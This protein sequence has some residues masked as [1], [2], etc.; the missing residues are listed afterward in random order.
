MVRHVL[1]FEVAAQED[2]IPDTAFGKL[3]KMVQDISETVEGLNSNLIRHG[4]E[5][6]VHAFHLELEAINYQPIN[7]AKAAITEYLKEKGQETGISQVEIEQGQL[8]M[9]TTFGK[10]SS[11]GD[12]FREVGDRLDEWATELQVQLDGFRNNLGA[13]ANSMDDWK[14]GLTASGP[15]VGIRELEVQL[16][17]ML[18]E[19][20]GEVV[21]PTPEPAPA[22]EPTPE[23]EQGFA[24]RVK[25]DSTPPSSGRN[26]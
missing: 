7:R 3:M 26:T 13:S 22:P 4:S 21:L 23:Q 17:E 10:R 2:G 9:D 11:A 12:F 6:E 19:H 14:I 24:A 20:N 15:A 8:R 18:I 1:A 25:K 5:K 16:K